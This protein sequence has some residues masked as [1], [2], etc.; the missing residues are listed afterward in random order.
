MAKGRPSE[1][2]ISE[3]L[4]PLRERNGP[5][6]TGDEGNRNGNAGYDQDGDGD[7]VGVV[8]A[9]PG[10][11]ENYGRMRQRHNQRE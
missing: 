3:R 4:I 10:G 5:A 1:K 2:A 8:V 6:H 11:P 9:K 7:E